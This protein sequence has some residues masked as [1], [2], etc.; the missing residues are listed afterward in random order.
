MF[1][2]FFGLSPVE[3]VIIA[4]LVVTILGV[5]VSMSRRRED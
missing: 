1:G 3:V 5:L 4:V 2:I